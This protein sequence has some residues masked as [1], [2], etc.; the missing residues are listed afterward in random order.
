MEGELV[1]VTGDSTMGQERSGSR[2]RERGL[3]GIE[4]KKAWR[5][6]VLNLHFL[7]TSS[8]LSYSPFMLPLF[9]NLFKHPRHLGSYSPYVSHHPTPSLF[10]FSLPPS[11]HL[12][13]LG[14]PVPCTCHRAQPF[15]KSREGQT[16]FCRTRQS[17]SIWPL[18]PLVL[19]R[20][21]GSLC[22]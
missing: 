9:L 7:L 16:E 11:I 22:I 10:P 12:S 19:Y 21:P 13:I 6:P 1:R 2:D 5:H 17:L 4:G 3:R 14:P 20:I 18:F 15:D 8:L